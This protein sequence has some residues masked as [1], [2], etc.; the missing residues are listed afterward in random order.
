MIKVK[1]D[2]DVDQIIYVDQQGNTKVLR[3]I[4]SIYKAGRL[5]WQYIETNF[6]TKDG[7]IFMSRDG[8]IMFG[9]EID[10]K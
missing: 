1:K 6:I 8:K 5:L 9:K 7:K 10:K 2:K 4:T 3:I